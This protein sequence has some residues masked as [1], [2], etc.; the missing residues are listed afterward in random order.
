M[1]GVAGD[2]RVL[3]IT[4][5]SVLRV[6]PDLGAFD[7]VVAAKVEFSGS[8][9]FAELSAVIDEVEGRIRAACP[10]ARFIFLEPDVARD[11]ITR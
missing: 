10:R 5:G 6:A 9:G 3:V 4:G 7:L 8:L 1:Q 2:K 11:D